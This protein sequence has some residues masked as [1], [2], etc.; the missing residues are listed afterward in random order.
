MKFILQP[1]A[2]SVIKMINNT[3]NE[4]DLLLIFSFGLYLDNFAIRNF[5]I[6]L[7]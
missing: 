6:Y 2:N 1:L 4:K 7:D 3:K 5:K